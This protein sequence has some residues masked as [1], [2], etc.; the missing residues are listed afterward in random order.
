MKRMHYIIIIYCFYIDKYKLP[1]GLGCWTDLYIA[2]PSGA[3]ESL[4][5]QKKKNT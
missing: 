3:L 4:V 2:A 5:S 1:V